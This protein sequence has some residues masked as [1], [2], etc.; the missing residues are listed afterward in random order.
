MRLQ[1]VGFPYLRT[2]GLMHGTIQPEGIEF[3]YAIGTGEQLFL[4]A[5]AGEAPEAKEAG[6]ALYIIDHAREDHDHIAV[7]S[8]QSGAWT[9]C[10][11]KQ[12][13]Y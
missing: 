1:Y 13:R 4:R 2:L 5:P 9:G 8:H 10:S 11:T 3:E 6:F 12:C 7:C